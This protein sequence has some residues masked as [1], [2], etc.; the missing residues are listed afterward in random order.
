M[1]SDLIATPALGF[2]MEL[3]KLNETTM[4]S[5]EI[6]ELCEKRHDNVMADIRKMLAEIGKAAPDFSGTALID[7]PNGSQRRIEVFNLTKDLTVTLITGYRADLRYK[8]IKRLEELESKPQV[9][10]MEILSDPAKMRGL[11]LNYVEQVI[12]LK[13]KIE[14]MRPAVEVHTRL[15]DA[16]GSVTITTAA[17]TLQVRPKDLS[18]WLTKN[19][20]I[21]KRHGSVNHLGFQDKCNAGYLTQKVTPIT[22]PDGT[23]KITEQVRITPK[24]LA[25]LATVFANV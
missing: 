25:K 18:E 19:R 20:W 17:K 3:V 9:N 5:R 11:L 14:V 22:R 13:D 23:E 2:T 15:V 4:S 6:A 7:G 10:P 16:E 8:V 21:Y 24:G 1:I 12:E